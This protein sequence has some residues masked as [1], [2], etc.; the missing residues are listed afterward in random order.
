MPSPLTSCRPCAKALPQAHI[1]HGRS[2]NRDAV[3]LLLCLFLLL[4]SPCALGLPA[5]LLYVIARII[6]HT[7]DGT[8]QCYWSYST[9]SLYVFGSRACMYWTR[10]MLFRNRSAVASSI[11]LE[12]K[13]IR[14]PVP[15][16]ILKCSSV[17]VPLIRRASSS[18]SQCSV[19]IRGWSLLAAPDAYSM[20]QSCADNQ[21]SR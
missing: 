13:L 7:R 8:V 1:G 20:V 5:C 15:I 2:A 10:V 17:L 16:R 11:G 18:R 4:S 6:S 12:A 21:C 14:G 3:R 19:V 9:H